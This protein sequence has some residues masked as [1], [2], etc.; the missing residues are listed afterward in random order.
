MKLLNIVVFRRSWLAIPAIVLFL[1]LGTVVLWAQIKIPSFD[2]LVTDVPGI[3]SKSDKAEI[4][5][6]LRN[7]KSTKGTEIAVLI[8]DS[9]EGNSE[10]GYAQEVVRVWKIGE[11]NKDNGILLLVALQDRTIRIE[12][13][14]GLEGSIPDIVVGRLIREEMLPIF[15]S[16]DTTGGIK[17]GVQRL[18]SLSS[19]EIPLQSTPNA[20]GESGGGVIWVLVIVGV[21]L[22]QILKP[23]LGKSLGPLSSAVAM[24][25]IGITLYSIFEAIMIFMLVQVF[26]F[27]NSGSRGGGG[28]GSWGGG[29]FGGG[30]GGSISFGG[31]GTFS[32]GG[33]SGRW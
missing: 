29:S 31:G 25:L 33:A 21:I 3:L 16:G 27:G 6:K 11:E 18:I 28:F 2:A 30:G 26:S 22:A 14:R 13:G 10:E 1:L 24:G 15:R 19:S 23:T 8:I 9:L 7:L 32:G 4:E 5:Q 12:V 17:L 20:P